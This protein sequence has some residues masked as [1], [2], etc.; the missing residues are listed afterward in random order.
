MQGVRSV[1]YVW[2]IRVITTDHNGYTR[3]THSSGCYWRSPS[4]HKADRRWVAYTSPRATHT[5]HHTRVFLAQP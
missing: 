2:R 5:T 1:F 3:N 4:S